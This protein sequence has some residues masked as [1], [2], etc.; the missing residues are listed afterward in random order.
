MSKHLT[1]LFLVMA[2]LAGGVSGFTPWNL[3]R[4][5]QISLPLDRAEYSYTATGNGVDVYVVDSGVWNHPDF[6]GRVVTGYGKGQICNGHGTG[7]AGVIGS[8]TY[9]VAK[10]V[11]II[12]VH[13]IP[14]DGSVRRVAEIERGFDWIIRESKRSGRRSVM[15]MSFGIVGSMLGIRDRIE[16]LISQGVVVVMAAGNES[17]DACNLISN[18]PG[19]LTVGGT[20]YGYDG[21]QHF[22]EF[23]YYS[24]FGPCVDIYAP[25]ESVET[26]W[27]NL[28][29]VYGYSGTSF[30][31]PHVSGVAAIYLERNPN[32]SVFDVGNAIVGNATPLPYGMFLYS[33][34]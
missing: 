16:T 17:R 9:G 25:A 26:I 23:L 19:V 24:N 28:G 21:T 33:N 1:N 13:V 8:A 11:R 29:P 30:A 5:D 10:D 18:I 6:E 22:D 32:A 14:C 2:I 15:N 27:N 12:D 20:R 4:I 34:F 7:V 3:D 31:A